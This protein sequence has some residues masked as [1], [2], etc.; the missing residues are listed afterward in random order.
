MGSKSCKPLVNPDDIFLQR[1]FVCCLLPAAYS[2]LPSVSYLLPSICYIRSAVCS[3][4]PS[5]CYQLSGF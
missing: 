5:L 3:L 4:L 2:L 1:E